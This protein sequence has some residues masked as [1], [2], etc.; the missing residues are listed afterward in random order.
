MA[1]DNGW[2]SAIHACKED[3]KKRRLDEDKRW[4]W[5]EKEGLLLGRKKCS[6]GYKREL[7]G[8]DSCIFLHCAT[9]YMM[10]GFVFW[11]KLGLIK[12]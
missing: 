12:G 7:V 9:D 6:F 1:T 11:L 10:A 5:K 8:I 3:R 4:D 2:P